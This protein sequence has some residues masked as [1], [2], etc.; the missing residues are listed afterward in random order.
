MRRKHVATLPIAR[1]V[2]ELM[3]SAAQGGETPTQR[4][5]ELCTAPRSPA[6][7]AGHGFLHLHLSPA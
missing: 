4:C 2:L 1:V 6:F 3:Q 5:N 7:E